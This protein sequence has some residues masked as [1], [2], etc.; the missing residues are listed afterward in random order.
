MSIAKIRMI[1]SIS[2]NKLKNRIKYIYIQGMLEV[3]SIE[4]TRMIED[5]LAMYKRGS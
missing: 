1:G 4:D 2:D 3:V 5:G